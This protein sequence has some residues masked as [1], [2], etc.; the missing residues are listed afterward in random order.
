MLLQD[1]DPSIIAELL[2]TIL[3]GV[4][5]LNTMK[6]EVLKLSSLFTFERYCLRLQQ[7]LTNRLS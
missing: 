7:E 5:D 1:T 6:N 4:L 3:S 2:D